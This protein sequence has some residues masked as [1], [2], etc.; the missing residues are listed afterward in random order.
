MK[1]YKNQL[2]MFSKPEKHD[3]EYNYVC[4]YDGACYPNPYGHMGVGGVIYKGVEMF[5]SISLYIPKSRQTS[6][7]VAEYMGLQWVLMSL[8]ENGLQDE[9]IL[10]KGDSM[11]VTN[12][13]N[14]LWR[15]KFGLYQQYAIE[16]KSLLKNFSD[17]CIKWIPREQNEEA[18][19]LSR[20]ELE[21]A[22]GDL[23][24]WDFN[25]SENNR[26]I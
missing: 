17:I 23:S 9:T 7:N 5:D 12:Q 11:L 4:Y 24:E 15:I 14:D 13:M 10:I 20:I 25:N 19:L 3:N 26:I 8:L 22:V 2:S 18:D 1:R 16:T 21:K 6:N